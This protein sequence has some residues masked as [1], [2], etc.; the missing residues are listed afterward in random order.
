MGHLKGGTHFLVVTTCKDGKACSIHSYKQFNQAVKT[1]NP[2]TKLS[3]LFPV[4]EEAPPD[5]S[6][7]TSYLYFLSSI[8]PGSISFQSSAKVYVALGIYNVV[9]HCQS[10]AEVKEIEDYIS[11]NDITHE[12]WTIEMGN[13]VSTSNNLGSKSLSPL[14]TTMPD[15]TSRPVLATAREYSILQ[16]SCLTSASNVAP[17][18][19]GALKAYNLVFLDLISDEKDDLGKL[20]DLVLANAALSKF[21]SQCFGGTSPLIN[22]ET[23]YMTHSLLGIGTAVRALGSIRDFVSAIFEDSKFEH[24]IIGLKELDCIRK[25]LISEPIQDP[26]FGTDI[27]AGSN[28]G[29]D[30]IVEN[31]SKDEVLPVIPFYSG[32]DG[33]RATK[34]SLSAPIESIFAANTYEWT[35]MTLTHE[36]SHIII[37]GCVLGQFL[38]TSDDA[39]LAKLSGLMDES[40]APDSLYEQAAYLLVHGF[41][42]LACEDRILHE[43]FVN[44]RIHIST[45]YSGEN[46]AKA[47]KDHSAE[48]NEILTHIFD[49]LYFY[50]GDAERYLRSV[51]MSWTVVPNI[52]SRIP[53]YITRCL[54]AISAVNQTEKTEVSLESFE[55]ILNKIVDDDDHETTKIITSALAELTLNREQYKTKVGLRQSLIKFVLS[56]LYSSS[57]AASLDREKATV[58]GKGN[59][60]HFSDKEF[61][62]EKISNPLRFLEQYCRDQSPDA[63]KTVWL[64][65]QLAFLAPYD[66]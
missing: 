35:L 55:K 48:V 16:A 44:K 22:S 66:S 11:A 50:R 40:L 13:V 18:L 6:S 28:F 34:F 5:F 36:L 9:A 61:Q 14:D 8:Y 52:E 58:R 23:G 15:V 47:V 39:W 30:K 31:V 12:Q 57:I 19:E 65:N 38:D 37:D 20:T 27:L 56:F 54:C 60:Y 17:H 64:L 49:C 43:I 1:W 26:I 7:G 3:P 29:L 53:D 62:P 51:W 45:D 21:Y 2:F 32:R 10:E 4:G 42:V 46:I 63:P 41:M 24:R 25:D 33:F 59:A